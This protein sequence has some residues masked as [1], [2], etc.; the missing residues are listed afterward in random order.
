MDPLEGRGEKQG[1]AHKHPKQGKIENTSRNVLKLE[2]E[3][4]MD[5]TK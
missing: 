2:S 3:D 5:F 1:T 4:I